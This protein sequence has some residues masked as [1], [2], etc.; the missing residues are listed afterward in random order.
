MKCVDFLWSTIKFGRRNY[1]GIGLDQ[2]VINV[3]DKWCNDVHCLN[4]I[5]QGDGL[6]QLEIKKKKM[7]VVNRRKKQS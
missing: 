3:K 2:K 1:R 5:Y 4:D 7:V 6:F